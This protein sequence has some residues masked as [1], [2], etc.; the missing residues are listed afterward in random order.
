M[1]STRDQRR[2]DD[3]DGAEHRLDFRAQDEAR[4][5][6]RSGDEIG[7]ILAG[8]REPGEPA[9]KLPGGH[10][11]HRHQ[12]LQRAVALTETAPQH[13][14]RRDQIEH[15]HKRL[16]HQ[17][18]IAP[19]QNPFLAA[20]RAPRRSLAESRRAPRLTGAGLTGARRRDGVFA[21]PRRN[22]RDG[23]GEQRQAHG[24]H[25]RR[26]ET[27]RRARRAPATTTRCHARRQR[28][29]RI[30]LQHGG[31]AKSSRRTGSR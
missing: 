17:P 29:Q 9:G 6:R 31:R 25:G 5:H 8:D 13:Q 26:A 11:Q 12:S 3:G 14:R 22:D 20:Q 23:G 16:R 30:R 27:A 21:E 2:E 19:Q 18:R 10:D 24:Q 1:A 4:R 28:Q 7:R 15:L